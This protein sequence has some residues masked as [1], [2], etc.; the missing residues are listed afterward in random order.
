MEEETEKTPAEIDLLNSELPLVDTIRTYYRALNLKLDTPSGR[1]QNL[2]LGIDDTVI[3]KAMERFSHSKLALNATIHCLIGCGI[4]EVFGVA[5]GIVL[6]LAAWLS[7]TVGVVFGFIGGFSLGIIPIV[8]H[9]ESPWSAF[10]MI[11]LGEFVSIVVM[12]TAEV[13]AE[14][15]IPGVMAASLSEPIFWFGM[16]TALVAGFIAAYSVNYFMVKRGVRH[17]H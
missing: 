16:L 1:Y 6:G 12:E 14:V 11:F 17:H 2:L 15:F 10:K 8:K 4:G 13:L 3:L 7:I 5:I 9:G